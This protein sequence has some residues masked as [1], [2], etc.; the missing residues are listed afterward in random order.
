[1]A[2]QNGIVA[3]LLQSPLHGLLST[4]IDLIRYEGRRSGRTVTTPTQY[5]REGSDVLIIVGHPERKTW[6]RNFEAERD[7]DVLVRREWLPMR[8]QV[9]RGAE[10]PELAAP[11][12]DAYLARFPRAV[13]A[14]GDGTRD[15]LVRTAVF[16]RCRPR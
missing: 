6:W 1:M 9:V 8:G 7:I 5:A 13:R 4:K 12:L 15:E 2:M 14:L 16:V 10:Q 3:W 11:L